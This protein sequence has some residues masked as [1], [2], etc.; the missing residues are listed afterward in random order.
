[1]EA[2]AAASDVR[3]LTRLQQVLKYCAASREARRTWCYN[4]RLLYEQGTSDGADARY[5]KIRA[6]LDRVASYL[7][8]PGTARFGVH[9]PPAHRAPWLATVDMVRSEYTTTWRESGADIKFVSLLEWALVYGATIGKAQRHGSGFKIGYIEPWD[10]GV[11]REVV[12]ELDEQDYVAHWYTMSM[13]QVERW[14]YGDPREQ[15]LIE[16]AE[17]HKHAARGGGA[18]GLGLAV[19]GI[20]GSFPNSTVSG[21]ATGELGDLPGAIMEEPEVELVDVWERRI[22]RRRSSL[23]RGPDD[24]F[25]DWIVT[26]MTGDGAEVFTQRRNPDLPWTRAGHGIVLPAELP[27][28]VVCP[29]PQSDYFWGRSEMRD[30]LRLQEWLETHLDKMSQI[31]GRKLDPSR[32][33]SGVSQDDEAARAMSTEGGSFFAP[34]QGAKM[35]QLKVD[36]GSEAFEMYKL[37]MAAFA[38]MSGVPEG[39]ESAGGADGGDPRNFSQRAGIMGG[40]IRKQALMFEDAIGVGAT[41]CFRLMQRH[42]PTKYP[43]KDGE[44][45]LLADLPA[46]THVRVDAHSAAPIYAE[47]T[48]AKMAFLAQH[49]AIRKPALVRGVD[50]PDADHLAEE[51]EEIER[52]EAQRSQE[53]MRIQEEKARKKK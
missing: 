1:M 44:T 29:R 25:E 31:L 4:K 20:S 9:L 52:G 10:F 14:A 33:F 17:D 53:I 6:H 42:D 50:P 36:I 16:I 40:R 30:L 37:I 24:R 11:S 3:D 34:E 46:G 47:Q 48:Q 26:T 18:M 43:K 19:T 41:K 13:P 32:F 22:V 15:R 2:T 23:G 8:A 35:E 51:A 21:V 45:F 12:P 38:D 49:K 7:Y 39:L 5:K 28:F 27:F